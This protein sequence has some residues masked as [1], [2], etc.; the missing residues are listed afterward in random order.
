MCCGS[1]LCSDTLPTVFDQSLEDGLVQLLD[2]RPDAALDEQLRAV[3]FRCPS[4]AITV[5]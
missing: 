2:E 3:A 1:G 5:G 4:R